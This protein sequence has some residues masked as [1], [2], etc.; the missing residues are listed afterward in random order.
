MG[1]GMQNL[2][3]SSSS[4]FTSKVSK[5]KS[6][7]LTLLS[8]FFIRSSV[9]LVS[10]ERPLEVRSNE[11][12]EPI[13]VL[14]LTSGLL[15]NAGL[16]KLEK[17]EEDEDS[18]DDTELIVLIDDEDVLVF[19]FLSKS[20][21]SAYIFGGCINGLSKNRGSSSWDG[22]LRR[23]SKWSDDPV[24]SLPLPDFIQK[25]SSSLSVDGGDL[26]SSL[27]T[28]SVSTF[29]FISSLQKKKRDRVRRKE[30]RPEKSVEAFLSDP[31]TLP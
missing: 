12:E 26:V 27:K 21:G 22:F 30:T 9:D 19:E 4:S 10:V 24:G 13:E 23:P 20:T 28:N 14:A 31:Q 17:M 3:K 15:G 1:D 2:S 6:S 18:K 5:L 7:S 25:P 29:E 11:E 8:N 16:A